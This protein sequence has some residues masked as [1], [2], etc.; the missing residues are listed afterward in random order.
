MQHVVLLGDSIF[1]NGAYVAGGPDVVQQ[2]RERL[3]HGWSATL[4]AVDGA[5]TGGVERQLQRL[6]PDTSQLVASVG[7]ND[8]LSHAGLLEEGARSVAEV[9]DR[10]S[11]VREQFEQDYRTMLDAVL[12][13]N[14]PTSVHDLRCTLSRSTA[15]QARR[16]CVDD[17]QR[18]HHSRSVQAWPAADRSAPALQRG[19]RFRQPDRALCP[20]WR[21]D[22]DGDRGCCRGTRFR[23]TV[24]AV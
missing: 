23:A 1:D 17:L 4:N 2:L 5:V 3:P 9:L 24:F 6:Q 8:A 7:G 15:A 21:E 14:L 16:H 13:R 18:R 10:I 20:R 11:D 19:R 22:R 12:S